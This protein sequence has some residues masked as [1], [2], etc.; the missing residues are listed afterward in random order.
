MIRLRSTLIGSTALALALTTLS[1]EAAFHFMKV[2]QFFPGSTAAPNAQYVMLQ[3]YFGGQNQVGGHQVTLYNSA[4][5]LIGTAQFPSMVPNGA[6]Q[7]TILVGSAESNAFF[8]V[9]ADLTFPVA[10]PL[11]GGMVC[12]DAIP[13]DC[14]AWG[15]F[16]GNAP[17]GSGTTVGTPFA[18]ATGLRRN[19]AVKRDLGNTTLEASDDTDNSAADFDP[20][21]P[22]PRNNARSTGTIPPSTCGNS[23]I[24]SLEA[25]DDGNTSDGDACNATCTVFT[26]DVFDDGFEN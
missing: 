14:V 25:C 17:G 16:T 9:T 1:A 20:A 22:S 21:L 8:N 15:A 6:D 4:G 5:V 18:Q 26:D 2:V 19:E 3:M 12:F 13:W 11:A 10:L 24:E 23:M 7:D